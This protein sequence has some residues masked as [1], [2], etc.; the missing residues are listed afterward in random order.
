MRRSLLLGMCVCVFWLPKLA[1][2]DCH[3]RVADG[4]FDTLSTAVDPNEIGCASLVGS[5]S[6][7]ATD[8]TNFCS[9]LCTVDG[10]PNG[11][12]ICGGSGGEGPFS[13]LWFV[14]FGGASAPGN[15]LLEV[16]FVRQNVTINVG[17][18]VLQFRLKINARNP[19][20]TAQTDF[21]RA[22]IDGNTVYEANVTTPGFASYTLIPPVDV[23]AFAS[24][25][26][27]LL[28]VYSESLAG[29][30]GNNPSEFFVDD[31]SLTNCDATPTVTPT[32]TST[33]TATTTATATATATVTRTATTTAT[34]TATATATRTATTT[35]T[36][37]AIATATRT[38]TP[39]RTLT[40]TRTPTST[41]SPTRTSTRTATPKPTDTRTATRTR[42]RTNT[43]RP[44]TATRTRTSTPR[45]GT[46]ARF[47]LSGL[48]SPIEV[49]TP[50]PTNLLV[51]A[52]DSTGNV[53]ASYV[54]RVQFDSS[55]PSAQRPGPTEFRAQ[56]GGRRSFSGVIFRQPGSQF[57]EAF[58]VARPGVRGQHSPIDVR[59]HPPGGSH[60]Y[61]SSTRGSNQTGNGSF[62]NPWQTIQFGHD[63]LVAGQTLHVLKGSYN[64]RLHLGKAIT[65][66]GESITECI[67]QPTTGSG[68][69]VTVRPHAGRLT[70]GRMTIVGT[71]GTALQAGIDVYGADVLLTNN[72]IRGHRH[73][74]RVNEEAVGSGVP[75]VR[76]NTIAA[77]GAQGIWG[78]G[79]AARL[80]ANLLVDSQA[81][82][83]Y[84]AGGFS[85]LLGAIVENGLFWRNH[86]VLCP[87]N[88]APAAGNIVGKDPRFF[89]ATLF[90]FGAGSPAFDA[91]PI[92][93]A[94]SD[95]D[96]TRNDVGAYGGPR[97]ELHLDRVAEVGHAEPALSLAMGVLALGLLLQR[98]RASGEL[99]AES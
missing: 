11:D 82:G 23:S 47:R 97:G 56:D 15:P 70:F 38:R 49:E 81:C 68:S 91:G 35:A 17:T 52:V 50:S 7:W 26:S 78:R 93:A 3:E 20:G 45:P 44:P 72:V 40:G 12:G 30:D 84:D 90:F 60:F 5:S 14:W 9:V 39:T 67:L 41:T 16:G 66:L 42:T 31:V 13:P 1:N 99:K 65:I 59:P 88:S 62:A 75:E 36:A 73:G 22:R 34:A 86:D 8:S 96:G 37:T 51:E 58:D 4:A 63:R 71:T 24:G 28:E 57:I 94:F 33:R 64:E 85:P 10:P 83:V 89:N 2:A 80:T 32:A 98:R 69:S 29:V 74:V 53:V 43:P 48:T 77:S 87:G 25:G 46:V 6:V 27:H 54:G 92:D 18:A 19:V 61:V 95:V 76:N 21:V 55:D 79:S